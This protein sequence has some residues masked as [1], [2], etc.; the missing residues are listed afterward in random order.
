[1][2]VWLKEASGAGSRSGPSSDMW[3]P[4]MKRLTA[5][6]PSIRPNA[7]FTWLYE[8]LN[9]TTGI[10]S[11]WEKFGIAR[12]HLPR[13]ARLLSVAGGSCKGSQGTGSL[14]LFRVIGAIDTTLRGRGSR[15]PRTRHAA[16]HSGNGGQIL[17]LAPTSLAAGP[18]PRLRTHAYRNAGS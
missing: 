2:H 7:S 6:F 11:F 10:P 15:H 9:Y 8:T 5:T 12:K 3:S 4:F 16:H 17:V 1:V 18:N 13:V 14:R